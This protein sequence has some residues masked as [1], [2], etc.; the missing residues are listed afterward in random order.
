MQRQFIAKR[1]MTT[2]IIIL[3]KV[4]VSQ[5]TINPEMYLGLAERNIQLINS[6]W[7]YPSRYFL[8]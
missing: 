1:I 8:P 4:E 3:L 6:G 5:E 7:D 2:S